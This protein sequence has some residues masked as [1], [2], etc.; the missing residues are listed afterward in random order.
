MD[1]I[2]APFVTDARDEAPKPTP[3][4]HPTSPD[5][6]APISSSAPQRTRFLAFLD[7]HHR[8][9][10]R[11]AWTYIP[12][13][14]ALTL[15]LAATDG[16]VFEG[17]DGAADRVRLARWQLLG[18]GGVGMAV[19]WRFPNAVRALAM[20]G[21]L[22]VT[23]IMSAT[24]SDLGGPS[25][26][27]PHFIYPFLLSP[28]LFFHTPMQRGAHVFAQAAAVLF[29][30]FGLHPSYLRDPL[31][32]ATV[33]F[34]VFIALISLIYGHRQDRMRVEVFNIKQDLELE[35]AHLRERVRE[36]VHDLS[37]LV[38]HL[39]TAR[40][41]ERSH[42]ARELHDELGQLLTACRLALKL[43]RTRFQRRPESIGAN[44]DHVHELILQLT[45]AT[46][47]L[48][49]GMR[50]PV[51]ESLGLLPAIRSLCERWQSVTGCVYTAQLPD[52]LPTLTPAQT[53][54]VFRCVQEALTNTARHAHAQRV[55]VHL[56]TDPEHLHLRV[57]DDG[58][59]LPDVTHRGLGLIGMRERV[60][61]LGGTHDLQSSPGRGTFLRISVPLQTEA[62]P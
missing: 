27:W 8:K 2:H 36:Q 15:V 30:S 35:R 60:E 40:E 12:L 14:L 46:R 23:A 16:T 10:R 41:S 34:V 59:G 45:D 50:I 28:L 56:H 58:R 49:D 62:A 18:L 20:G 43:A 37:L 47:T 42:V 38:H 3:L 5:P 24:L 9:L 31:A 44:L 55:D 33:I 61:A 48:L 22:G 21:A 1:A 57:S 17:I 11:D 29:T 25:T 19:L 26:A 13:L 4:P 7:E 53:S 54:T 51:V 52:A 39:D 32:G 6:V